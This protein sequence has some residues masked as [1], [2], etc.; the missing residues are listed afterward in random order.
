MKKVLAIG[1]LLC[2]LI[3]PSL[4]E[5]IKGGELYYEYRGPGTAAGTAVYDLYL[6]LYIDCNANNPGQ[7]DTQIPISVFDKSNNSLVANPTAGM[8]SEQFI[9]FDPATN[10]CIGNPPSD[11]CYRVRIFSTTVTLPINVRGYTVA[12][13]RCCRIANIRNLVSPSNAVGA[14]YNKCFIRCIYQQ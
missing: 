8:A 12:Y 9:R 10:P 11:V 2:G 1:I 6:K 13:Q 5:H 4:A 3:Q 7:L 14:T